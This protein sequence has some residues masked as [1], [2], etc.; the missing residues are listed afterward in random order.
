MA[1]ALLAAAGALI[2]FLRYGM[3]KCL[4]PER[5]ARVGTVLLEPRREPFPPDPLFLKLADYLRETQGS[6]GGWV[7]VEETVWCA[8]YLQKMPPAYQG[9]VIDARKWLEGQ[10]LSEGGW[11]RSDRD[12]PRIPYTAWVAVLL[13][14]LVDPQDLLW[15]EKATTLEIAGEPV[16]T[17]KVA[18]PLIAFWQNKYAPVTSPLVEAGISNLMT[19]QNEDGGF[20][21]WQNHPC[22]SDPWCTA[23]VSLAL[24]AYREL[25]SP[26]IIEKAMEWLLRH[27]LQGGLWPYH[28]IDEGSALAY[29]A[30]KELAKWRHGRCKS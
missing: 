20:G 5:L 28:Y 2:A 8:A 12:R 9:A 10:R 29:W 18:L 15:L 1:E 11:G 27:Q 13:P 30:L 24:L 17:Y 7:D 19:A 22:G 4:D 6:D 23:I 21:A 26:V 25:I 14:G 3:Q 16:L